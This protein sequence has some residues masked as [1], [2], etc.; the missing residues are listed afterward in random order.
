[1]TTK[2]KILWLAPLL[3][4]ALI[5]AMIAY[6]QPHWTLMDDYGNI[7]IA[8]NMVN[9][10]FWQT[11]HHWVMEDI[12]TNGRLRLWNPPMMALLYLPA[13]TNSLVMF[14]LNDC[15]IFLILFLCGLFFYES[16]K[17]CIGTI[18]KA[19]FISLFM[20][21]AFCY[22]WTHFL[23]FCPSITE[24]LVLFF[25][26]LF[27]FTIYKIDHFKN[28]LTWLTA[29]CVS[30]ILALNTKEQI[31]FF[32]PLFLAAQL[33]LDRKRQR[34]LRFGL[35]LLLLLAGAALIHWVGTHG[36]YKAKYGLENALL[37]VKKSKTL[38]AFPALA[39]F[40]EFM[41]LL[42][43]RRTRDHW[44][45]LHASAYPLGLLIF[46][47]VMLPWGLGFYINSA[48]TVFF[49][50]CCIIL[51]QS[52]QELIKAK[53]IFAT[54][55]LFLFPL[56]VLVSLL[57]TGGFYSALG[58]YG[59]LLATPEFQS[60]SE[61]YKKIYVPCEEG[62]VRTRQYAKAFH[63]I[64]VATDWDGPKTPESIQST[65]AAWIFSPLVC[66]N[67][68]EEALLDTSKGAKILF[69][70]RYKNGFY[71]VEFNH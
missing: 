32:F 12:F 61:K 56:A 20:V 63:G 48:A 70:G 50:L 37:N 66:S 23:F 11:A 4:C 55:S 68:Q 34:Y 46:V 16:A 54:A 40:T 71:L 18:H 10:G 57:K 5:L 29:I 36:Q 42:K 49:I 38:I 43:W 35:L 45:F 31:A 30:L 6:L 14:C 22:P 65:S 58:D 28:D 2:N 33:Q 1:M 8:K 51:L 21:L 62:S 47:V 9:Q 19:S 25:A 3:L 13:G 27:L 52:L 41:L 26:G 44:S 17:R 15:L 59:K 53:D 69:Q 7:D 39:I 64:E 67:G 60:V 24:K